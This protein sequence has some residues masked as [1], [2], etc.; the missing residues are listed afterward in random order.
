MDVKEVNGEGILIGE[1]N[2]CKIKKHRYLVILH[3]KLI[4]DIFI[5]EREQKSNSVGDLDDVNLQMVH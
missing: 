2:V 4:M 5:P 1:Y 3:S